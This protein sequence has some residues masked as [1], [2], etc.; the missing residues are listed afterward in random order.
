MQL[1]MKSEQAQYTM[2]LKYVNICLLMR[3]PVAFIACCLRHFGSYYLAIRGIAWIYKWNYEQ[4]TFYIPEQ[5]LIFH[6]DLHF[7][8]AQHDNAGTRRCIPLPRLIA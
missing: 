5:S 7:L 8:L 6:T 3:R 1:Q 4:N 2:A